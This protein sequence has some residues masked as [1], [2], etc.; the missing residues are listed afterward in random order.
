MYTFKGLYLIK[1][2][3][4]LIIHFALHTLP[5]TSKVGKNYK[6]QIAP[7]YL[8]LLYTIMRGE[9]HIQ[10]ILSPLF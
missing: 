2:I 3:F 10:F 6:Y 9:I 8:L 5:M 1:K 4:Q 7:Y